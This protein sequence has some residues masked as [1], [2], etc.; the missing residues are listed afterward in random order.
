MTSRLELFREPVV[1]I[2]VAVVI[3]AE[4]AQEI[5][6]RAVD[7]PALVFPRSHLALR[8]PPSAQLESNELNY[9]RI[10]T[11]PQFVHCRLSAR[12][13]KRRKGVLGPP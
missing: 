2:V 9:A 6:H 12:G 8:V 7:L 5:E 11:K 13:V 3:Q 4:P 10:C 1:S